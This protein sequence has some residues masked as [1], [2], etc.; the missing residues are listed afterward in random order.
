M[1]KAYFHHAADHGA[2][3]GWTTNLHFL[4]ISNAIEIEYWETVRAWWVSY[5]GKRKVQPWWVG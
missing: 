2:E 1:Q 3:N 4:E 5:L